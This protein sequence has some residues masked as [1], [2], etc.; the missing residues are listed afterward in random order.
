MRVLVLGGTG[1]LGHKVYQVLS[2]QFDTFATVRSGRHAYEALQLFAPGRLLGEAD[3]R[4]FNTVQRVLAEVTPN[5]VVN[6]I[7]VV[8]QVATA[9][10]PIA[11]ISLNA[12][13]PHLLEAA[14]AERAIRLIH[15]STD[16]VFS[17]KIGQYTEDDNPDPVDL[18]G[19]SK[20]LGEVSGPSSL[21]L[22]TS[23]IGREI[24]GAHGLVEWFL[25][26]RGCQVRGYTNAIFSGFTTVV[27]SKIIA[28]ILQDHPEMH[29]LYHASAEPISKYDL[30]ML[31]REAYDLPIEIEPFPDVRIDRS[32]NSQRFRQVTGFMPPSWST[33][34]EELASDST[35][36]GAWRDERA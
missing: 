19:R 8:K 17:G 18:Y 4:N 32:L 1:M 35:P 25:G 12:L 27:L 11:S 28:M 20:L 3:A 21:T 34:I 16:C 2:H 10:D 23:I 24:A 13:F 14:C 29:G 31:L 15:I 9:H 7:G 5:T 26:Q 22:R 6:C 33:M 36:Y 30:L